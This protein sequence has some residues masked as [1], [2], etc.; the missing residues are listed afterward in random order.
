MVFSPKIATLFVWNSICCQAQTKQ[1]NQ[2]NLTI[3]DILIKLS[4]SAVFRVQGKYAKVEVLKIFIGELVL[5]SF[6]ELLKDN[7]LGNF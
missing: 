2:V 1:T 5:L 7:N 3:D 6:P 4:A